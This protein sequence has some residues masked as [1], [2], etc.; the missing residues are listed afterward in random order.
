MAT[1]PKRGGF[2]AG[3]RRISKEAER[4]NSEA[5]HDMG[6]DS[7]LRIRLEGP[8]THII[9]RENRSDMVR[10]QTPRRV[11][12]KWSMRA[13]DC[14]AGRSREM[15]RYGGKAVNVPDWSSE[16]GMRWLIAWMETKCRLNDK[17]EQLQTRQQFEA[18][19]AAPME[20]VPVLD[21]NDLP[22]VF[23][24]LNAAM[25]LKIPERLLSIK[26]YVV[27]E[28]RRRPMDACEMEAF[29]TNIESMDGSE[30]GLWRMLDNHVHH[31]LAGT[32]GDY[33]AIESFAQKNPKLAGKMNAL[34]EAKVG[35]TEA[36][37]S[38]DD[39]PPQQHPHNNTNGLN[40]AITV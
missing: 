3:P 35:V 16:R 14:L 2:G 1:N 26:A 36:A 19:G 33:D 9:L 7:D 30:T 27:M 22:L 10:I 23:A 29:W 31:M 15:D 37:S 39:A 20:G 28:T 21:G 12:L 8:I 38:F 25:A 4:F 18:D 5:Y 40:G 17:D 24:V 11:V 32:P 34:L 13:R 6:G